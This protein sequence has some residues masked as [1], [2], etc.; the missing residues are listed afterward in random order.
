MR[1]TMNT[2]RCA[3]CSKD[4]PQ[5]AQHCVFCG[6]KQ[7][8]QAPTE[9]K[10]MLGYSVADIMGGKPAPGPAPMAPPPGA[11]GGGGAP[12]PAGP[13]G[14]GMGGPPPAMG[15]PP[16]MGQPPPGGG[17]HEARTMFQTPSGP[18]MGGPAAPMGPPGG[19]MGGPPM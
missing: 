11:F 19:G 6:Q 12:P 18:P 5:V 15:G 17:L 3:H 1:R 2:K 10:T 7:P 14:G 4:I 16:Q 9:A 8:Q 13:P